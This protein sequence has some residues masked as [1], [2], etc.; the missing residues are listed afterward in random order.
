MI[1]KAV[2][3]RNRTGSTCKFIS[4]KSSSRRQPERDVERTGLV[5]EPGETRGRSLPAEGRGVTL[6]NRFGW[7]F[8]EQR[9]TRPDT[10]NFKGHFSRVVNKMPSFCIKVTI[11]ETLF[12]HVHV[13]GH[14]TPGVPA[15]WSSVPESVKK[16]FEAKEHKL[17]EKV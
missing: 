14:T 7:V 11:C 12:I 8:K 9:E 16:E 5:R 15:N 4:K 1:R 2:A 10:A 13:D 3:V 17:K 6:A